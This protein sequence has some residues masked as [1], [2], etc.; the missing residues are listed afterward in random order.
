MD[1][2]VNETRRKIRCL[3]ADMLERE[4]PFGAN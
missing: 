4:A 2:R 3:R 1:N